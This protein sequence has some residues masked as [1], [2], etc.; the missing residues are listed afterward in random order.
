MKR[1]RLAPP[2]PD[3]NLRSRASGGLARQ[4]PSRDLGSGTAKLEFIFFDSEE[5][6]GPDGISLRGALEAGGP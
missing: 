4:P 6:F 1:I 2:V 5:S 3:L